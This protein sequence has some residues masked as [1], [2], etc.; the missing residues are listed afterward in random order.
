M[1]DWAG[2]IKALWAR[3]RKAGDKKKTVG[4]EEGHSLAVEG[5]GDVG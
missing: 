1:S 4:I 5:A 2:S 3:A